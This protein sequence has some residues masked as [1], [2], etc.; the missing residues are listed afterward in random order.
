MKQVH[1]VAWVLA[2]SVV[3]YYVIVFL[4]CTSLRFDGKVSD[5]C[6]EV[7]HPHIALFSIA[8]LTVALLAL[9]RRDVLKRP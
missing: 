7:F 9:F 3:L 4:D 6:F 8:L 1:V 5:Q 2:V